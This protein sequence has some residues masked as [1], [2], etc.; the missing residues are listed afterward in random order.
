MA[1]K[2]TRGRARTPAGKRP[3]RRGLV[4]GAGGILGSAWMIGALRA[5]EE[6]TGDDARSFDLIVGTSAG[7]V[8]AT[9]LTVGIDVATMADS[10]RGQYAPGAPILD[11]RE[12]GAAL[13]LPPRM[14][15]G[16]PRLLTTGVLHPH[17]LTPMVALAA[18]LPQGRGQLAAIGDLIGQATAGR[19]ADPEQWPAGL[20]I[21]AMDFDSGH[22]VLFGAHDAPT[23][24][25]AQAVMASC[26]IP[27]WY[28]PVTIDGRRFVDGGTRS[29]T[30]LDLC[31]DAG[32]DEILVLAPAYAFTYD[33]PHRP[34]AVVERQLRRAATRR[35][36][37]EIALAQAAGTRVRILCPG[38]LD[39]AAMGGNVM[40]LARRAGVFE[41]SLRTS[42]DAFTD[43]PRVPERVAPSVKPAAA[44]ARTAATRTTVPTLPRTANPVS[45]GRRAAASPGPTR[46]VPAPPL[47]AD[48]Q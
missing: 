20:R 39:L 4:L 38:P 41:T 37:A 47:I 24:P 30:S 26:A 35:L 31:V 23:A 10:E 43:L 19:L 29:P 16:S 44:A 7:S 36:A 13:P 12:L 6:Q 32:L 14:R 15:I 25:L 48:W 5:Y 33:H 1:S 17:R 45:A 42:A 18:L 11:Y 21:V 8:V 3:P 9:L 40:D 2:D 28:A 27:G 46:P 22:R 34:V